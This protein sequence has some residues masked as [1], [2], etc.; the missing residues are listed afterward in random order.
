[1]NSGVDWCL[2]LGVARLGDDMCTC[3]CVMRLFLLICCE[4]T[5]FSSLRNRWR[6]D[7]FCVE[8][9]GKEGVMSGFSHD[10]NVGQRHMGRRT[11]DVGRKS[12]LLEYCSR[13][14][15]LFEVC[16]YTLKGCFEGIGSVFR[17]YTKKSQIHS[18]G[19]KSGFATQ[20]SRFLEAECLYVLQ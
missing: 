8:N 2:K 17:G 1:M 20:K 15:T 6:V 9:S 16:R 19:K 12:T 13:R 11:A 10:T 14:E 5:H 18:R 7:W 3:H 4:G